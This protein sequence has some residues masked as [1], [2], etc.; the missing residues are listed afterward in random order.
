MFSFRGGRDY[1]GHA[2]ALERLYEDQ[3]YQDCIRVIRN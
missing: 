1:M 2:R 3:L